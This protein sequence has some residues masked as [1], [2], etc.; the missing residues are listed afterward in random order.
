MT[1]EM[2]GAGAK[3][4]EKRKVDEIIVNG[5]F[6]RSLKMEDTVQA[7]YKTCTNCRKVQI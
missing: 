2:C 7:P 4:E 3:S 1:H 5:N 6:K